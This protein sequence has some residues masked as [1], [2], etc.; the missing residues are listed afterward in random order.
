MDKFNYLKSKLS[1]EA[2]RSI[3]G[4]SLTNDNYSVA[5]D[6]FVKR[7]GSPQEIIDALYNKLI[8]LPQA[9][10]KLSNVR[11][12]LDCIERHLRSLEALKQNICQD[13]FAS[14]IRSKLPEKVLV[15]LELKHSVDKKWS[16]KELTDTL[17]EYVVARERAAK[18]S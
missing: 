3:E 15:Q 4:L 10:A 1:G 6:I 13:V 5:V 17:H 8:S 14:I 2:K 9:T 11:D 16:V 12:L 7:F 18:D